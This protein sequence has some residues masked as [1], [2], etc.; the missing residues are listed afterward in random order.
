[1]FGANLRWYGVV[2]PHHESRTP[3]NMLH[4]EW[5]VHTTQPSGGQH[6]HTTTA[7]STTCWLSPRLDPYHVHTMYLMLSVRFWG[8][9]AR[10][11]DQDSSGASLAESCVHVAPLFPWVDPIETDET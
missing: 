5:P 1:M 8:Y 4:S 9:L 6:D 7:R 2:E 3:F 11:N 10:F